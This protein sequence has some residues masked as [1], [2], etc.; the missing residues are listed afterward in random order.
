MH[1]KRPP[2]L[3]KIRHLNNITGVFYCQIFL[4]RTKTR[5]NAVISTVTAVYIK[6]SYFYIVSRQEETRFTRFKNPHD[7]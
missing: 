1:I 7:F 4:S 6:S 5:L 3:F 2:V